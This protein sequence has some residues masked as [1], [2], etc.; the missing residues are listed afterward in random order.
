FRSLKSD[1]L[2][3]EE[4][5]MQDAGRLFKLALIGLAAATRTVQLVDITITSVSSSVANRNYAAYAASKAG[6]AHVTRVLAAEWAASGVRVNALGPAVTPTPLAT[7]ILDDPITQD[8]ALA[9]IPMSRFGTP[10]DLLAA[11]I[12]LLAPGSRFITGQ[13]LY[14]DGGRTIS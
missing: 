10:E 9:R 6:A 14:V 1:G 4:T 3:L 8:A 11:I 7:Q 13:I 2:R 5:Q 12:F